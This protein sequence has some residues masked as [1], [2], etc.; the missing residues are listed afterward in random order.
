[1]IA[2]GLLFWMHAR[3][4][5]GQYNP[6]SI[7]VVRAIGVGSTTGIIISSGAFLISNRLMPKDFALDGLHRH[8]LEYWAFFTVWIAAFIHAAMR[9]KSAWYEQSYG[10]AIMATT[11]VLLN[12]FTTGHHIWAAANA[13]LW[14]IATMDVVLISISALAV[15]AATRLRKTARLQVGSTPQSDAVP[16]LGRPA[17]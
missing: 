16:P 15:W 17:E 6:V 9:G 1:M 11:A 3:I 5:I 7:R 2:S 14:S 4:K 13:S 8:D 10:I 12:W